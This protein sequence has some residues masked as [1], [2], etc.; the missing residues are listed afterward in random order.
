[1][2]ITKSYLKKVY[3]SITEEDKKKYEKQLD[4]NSEDKKATLVI[5]SD[6]PIKIIK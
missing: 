4:E 1:M 5:A 3:D 2:I 6:N